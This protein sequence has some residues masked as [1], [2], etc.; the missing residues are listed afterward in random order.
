MIIYYI[1]VDC[2]SCLVRLLFVL[3]VITNYLSI[4]DIFESIAWY[5]LFVYKHKYVSAIC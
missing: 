3:L 1:A 5:F 2:Q 4:C